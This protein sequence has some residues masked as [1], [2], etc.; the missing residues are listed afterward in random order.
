MVS[1]F[2]ILVLAVLL[3]GRIIVVKVFD[4]REEYVINPVIANVLT[5]ITIRVYGLT[6]FNRS[7]SFDNP[8]VR[9]FYAEDRGDLAFALVGVE[10]IDV[11]VEPDGWTDVLLPIFYDSA[12]NA[13][14][15]NYPLVFIDIAFSGDYSKEMWFCT[16]KGWELLFDYSVENG[17][18]ERGSGE[19]VSVGY[20]EYDPLKDVVY[21][22]TPT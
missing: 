9:V 21:L 22:P 17:L 2:V 10:D 7:I 16:G 20:V 8:Y 18:R 3:S 1:L 13:A 4:L 15:V 19:R 14:N 6:V 12:A 11:G 5:N